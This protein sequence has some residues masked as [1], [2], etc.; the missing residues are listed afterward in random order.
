[1]EEG[2]AKGGATAGPGFTVTE[3]DVAAGETPPF[4]SVTVTDAVYEP[5]VVGVQV[6]LGV[7]LAA[8]PSPGPEEDQVYEGKVPV[9]PEA[10]VVNVTLCPTSKE[11]IDGM[12]AVTEGR[13]RTVNGAE[14]CTADLV[15]EE[16]VT[17][18]DTV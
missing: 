16:S 1:M 6:M 15:P 10:V 5:A 12:G 4:E 8:H 14:V 18:T 3:D 13:G 9:P 7:V 2:F 17:E 11:V